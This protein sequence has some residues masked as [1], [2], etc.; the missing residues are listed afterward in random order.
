MTSQISASRCVV[1]RCR[2]GR[3]ACPA[4]ETCS[5]IV[6]RQAQAAE[7]ATEVGADDDKG[8]MEGAWLVT[9]PALGLA[10][11]IVAALVLLAVFWP[12]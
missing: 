8:P 6:G 11:W 1:D 3:S 12:G 2:Q 5:Y 7:A 10:V 9:A 4:P